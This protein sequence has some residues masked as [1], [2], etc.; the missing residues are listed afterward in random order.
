MCNGWLLH[1]S[2]QEDYDRLR[3]LSYSDTNVVLICFDVTSPNTFDNILTKVTQPRGGCPSPACPP[4]GR[5]QDC[6]SP[7]CPP[8]EMAW[9]WGCRPAHIPVPQ[10]TCVPPQWYPEVNHF[11][12]GVPVLLV[13]CKTDLRRDR[14]VLQKLREGHLEPISYQQASATP[15]QAGDV[16]EHRA[17]GEPGSRGV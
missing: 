7:V 10:V 11:C 3:P 6:P 16:P 12:R 14:E 17:V 1:P 8:W 15:H 9:S 2:G 4:R 13:G 5:W